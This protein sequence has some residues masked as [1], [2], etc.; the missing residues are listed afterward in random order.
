MQ[1]VRAERI[2]FRGTDQGIRIKSNRDRGADISNLSFKD[3]TMEGVGTSILV[4]EYYPRVMPEGEVAAAAV[5]RLTPHFHNIRIRNVKSVNGATAGVIVGLPE[6][7]VV[8]IKLTN[9]S[10]QAKK[11]LQIGYATVDLQHV[12]I[13]AEQGKP[14]ILGP[15][16]KV[17]GKF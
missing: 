15:R 7:P 4:S 12:Q 14:L 6:S 1:R 10:I 5:G 8:N 9:V 13:T 3:I 11:G 17:T 16:G 2:A